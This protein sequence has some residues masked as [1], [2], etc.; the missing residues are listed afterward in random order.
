MLLITG[1]A[2]G[3]VFRFHHRIF[4]P[5]LI[6][7]P[8][9]PMAA[10]PNLMLWAWETPEDLTQL[11]PTKAGVAFLSRE[12][13]LS[14]NDPGKIQIRPRLQPLRTAP[15]T[16]LMA[17]VRIET[18]PAFASTQASPQLTTEIAEAI[19]TAARAPSVLA[20]QVD[21]DATASQHAFYAALLKQVRSQLPANI[22]LSITALVSWCTQPSWLEQ[23]PTH[24]VDEAVPMF[25]RM[26]G[27]AASRATAPKPDP[28]TLPLCAT[29]IGIATDE[30]WPTIS[31]QQRVYVFRTGPWSAADIAKLN[32]KG[33][34]GLR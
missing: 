24:T 1:F 11:D 16:W 21:F 9:A 10:E 25:F 3:L 20:L 18:S 22:P 14:S 13:L 15:N 30:S 31:P 4:S 33:Y 6:A 2:L 17:V 27:P 34:Q 32:A 12:I 19:V 8:A 26:G 28:V 29:S 7:L 23:L 5:K